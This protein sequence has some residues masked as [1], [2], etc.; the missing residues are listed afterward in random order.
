MRLPLPAASFLFLFLAPAPIALAQKENALD[1]GTRSQMLLDPALV[2]ESASLALTVR[3]ARK[4]RA[5]PL[6]W[7]D[8]SRGAGTPPAFRTRNDNP[9]G[10]RSEDGVP[11]RSARCKIQWT[12]DMLP[13][14]MSARQSGASSS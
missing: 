11:Q 12:Y 3:T 9:C 10:T 14:K 2:Y 5:N 6:L 7:A 1:V 8:Q 4:H 13:R